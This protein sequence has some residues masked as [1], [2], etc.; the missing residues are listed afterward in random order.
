M[1][2]DVLIGSAVACG[3]NTVADYEMCIL[4][5]QFLFNVCI[6]IHYIGHIS[7]SNNL[8]FPV[9]YYLR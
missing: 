7:A 6:F 4:T 8:F 2:L 9:T 5:Y 3:D 1:S